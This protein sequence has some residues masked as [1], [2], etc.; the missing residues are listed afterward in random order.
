[1]SL[2]KSEKLSVAKRWLKIGVDLF[3][4][5]MPALVYFIYY[6]ADQTIFR[7]YWAYPK[8][9]EMESVRAYQVAKEVLKMHPNRIA[10]CLA[11]IGFVYC[12]IVVGI[13]KFR[14]KIALTGLI[15]NGVG[16]AVALFISSLK[17][18]FLDF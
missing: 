11:V 18:D 6:K 13:S 7:V 9:Q 12:A 4:A 5:F 1:M 16:L 3:M 17:F 8:I 14:A 10:I 15:L 2:S